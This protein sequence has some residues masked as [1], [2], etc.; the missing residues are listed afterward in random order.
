MKL[1]WKKLLFGLFVGVGM[2]MMPACS[3]DEGTDIDGGGQGTEVPEPTETGYLSMKLS[4]GTVTK[5][6]PGT[7]VGRAEEQKVQAVW[8][9]LYGRT[10]NVVEYFWE[11]SA[12]N[13]GGSFDGI[14]VSKESVATSSRF[15]TVG[16]PV[17]KKEYKMV[18]L[19]NPPTSIKGAFVKG[20]PIGYLEEP[21]ANEDKSLTNDL[22]GW[23]RDNYF[24]M[25]NSQSYIIVEIT[26]IKKSATD[27]ER[28]PK[29]V[30]VDRGV[31]KI[32]MDATLPTLPGNDNI[33]DLGW[34]LD[35]TNRYSFWLRHLGK[36]SD[37]VMGEET[38]DGSSRYERYAIDPNFQNCSEATDNGTPPTYQQFNY[39]PEDAYMKLDNSFGGYTY[40]LEN[41][42]DADEQYQDVTTRVVIRGR[43]RPADLRYNSTRDDFFTFAGNIITV[44]KMELYDRGYT[45][46]PAELAALG[47]KEAMDAVKAIHPLAFIGSENYNLSSYSI[48]GLNYYLNG[49][50]YYTVLIRHF[51]EDL[52]S[53]PMGYGRYGVV[54]NNVY[55]LKIKNISGIGSPIV[56]KPGPEPNDGETSIA[57]DIQVL[58]W[59]IR[60]Q[61]VEDL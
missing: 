34:G 43:Y 10:S 39:L 48:K 5:A 36:L 8:V 52:V 26:D 55:K 27:A 24:F 6:D 37:G 59:Q 35:V 56:E 32:V 41:T 11:L 33:E 12:T 40:A 15:V 29:P 23:A 19:V 61:E 25:S 22:Y 16:K 54:R 49:T 51:G 58:P 42:M 60:S 53:T 47:L 4:L 38:G 50:C 18:V 46:I 2:T 14:D 57:A 21:Y 7:E 30:L 9:I 17:D 1:D 45:P 31:A 28:N 13:T 3:N 44:E 20:E